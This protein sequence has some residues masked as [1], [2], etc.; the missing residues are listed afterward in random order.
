MNCKMNNK[1]KYI[2]SLTISILLVLYI[3]PAVQ[4]VEV[5]AK[6]DWVLIDRGHRFEAHARAQGH[7]V[8]AEDS[9]GWSTY[10]MYLGGYQRFS[11]WPWLG[12]K[13]L[14]KIYITAHFKEYRVRWGRPPIISEYWGPP[15][16]NLIQWN[17]IRNYGASTPGSV[18]WT[19]N[20][21]G[22]YKGFS[23]SF[24]FSFTPS[25]VSSW[26]SGSSTSDIYRYY[27]YFSSHYT[28]NE[29]S[30]QALLKFDVS[31]SLANEYY[32]GI[33]EDL[34][35]GFKI[36]SVLGIKIKLYWKYYQYYWWSWRQVQTYP[37]GDL[38]DEP[39]DLPEILL[40]PGEVTI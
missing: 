11:N 38:H 20:I 4:G 19:A 17:G 33:Y 26:G 30:F 31:N 35:D 15:P 10:T 32:D 40:Y 18:Q 8:F 29:H 13:I 22:E 3:I 1:N 27:G 12:T 36:T 16:L 24:G 6:D 25:A 28:P 2:I 37:N 7:F 23:M 9:S 34:P 39:G 21:G 14:T 5:Y